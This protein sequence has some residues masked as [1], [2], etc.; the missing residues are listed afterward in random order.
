MGGDKAD[1]IE[2]VLVHE[3]ALAGDTIRVAGG[4]GAVLVKSM[5]SGKA[6]T[7]GIAFELLALIWGLVGSA[8]LEMLIVATE[9]G[10]ETITRVAVGHFGLEFEQGGNAW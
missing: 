3:H 9:G 8:V 6:S 5:L 2:I 7:A 10:E 1:L 4:V